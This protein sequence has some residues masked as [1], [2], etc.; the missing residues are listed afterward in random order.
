MATTFAYVA[1]KV[2]D[3]TAD[4][5]AALKIEGINLLE[6]PKRFEPAG[7]LAASV[8]GQVGLDNQ[9][10]SGLETQF[11]PQLKGRPG[12]MVVE[13]DPAGKQI[14]SGLREV[15]PSVRG[16]DV[17]LTLDRTMQYETERALAQEIVAANA[18]GGIAIVADPQSGDILS[19]ASL[20]AGADG[21]PPG[22]SPSN[23]ALTTVY[24]TLG[25]DAMIN[26]RQPPPGPLTPAELARVVE[27]LRR[28]GR[29]TP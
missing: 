28:T 16:R 19:M 12:R 29:R 17:V 9:G 15:Q 13:H 26:F 8:L 6:E 1:R 7:D 10:L 23:A 11:E 4:K 25:Y 22:P 18:K 27:Q 20:T 5:V 14:A 2:D 21:Q 24:D 3:A